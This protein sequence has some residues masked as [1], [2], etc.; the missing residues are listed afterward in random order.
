M[1]HEIAQEAPLRIG[2][3]V[4]KLCCA[5]AKWALSGDTIVTACR[6]HPPQIIRREEPKPPLIRNEMMDDLVMVPPGEGAARPR[7]ELPETKWQETDK[8]IPDYAQGVPLKVPRRFTQGV[9]YTKP[10]TA[11]I[12]DPP[13]D[14]RITS[15][16]SAP[17]EITEADTQAI[18]RALGY[19]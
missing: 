19:A 18:W 12:G 17:T 13:K 1:S 11:Q 14:P 5:K 9:S 15:G 8:F 10:S 3:P 4:P 6:D 16:L 7:T 2:E